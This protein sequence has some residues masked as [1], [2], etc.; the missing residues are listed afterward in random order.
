ML[1]KTEQRFFIYDVENVAW[2]ILKQ[3]RIPERQEFK[4]KL[5]GLASD[6]SKEQ[7]FYKSS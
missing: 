4:N 3:N 1:D 7:I 5:L 2:E 6:K